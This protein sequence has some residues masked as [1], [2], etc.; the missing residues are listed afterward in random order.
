[1]TQWDALS[2][3]FIA[4]YGAMLYQTEASDE[5]AEKGPGR[6]VQPARAPRVIVRSVVP[7]ERERMDHNRHRT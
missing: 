6:L 4:N 2:D 5:P 7:A 3:T 1:M